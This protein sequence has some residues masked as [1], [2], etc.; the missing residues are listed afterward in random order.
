MWLLLSFV[1]CCAVLFCAAAA[2]LSCCDLEPA[3]P[4]NTNWTKS[5]AGKGKVCEKE[6]HGTAHTP[7]TA[8]AALTNGTKNATMDDD[9]AGH[10]HAGH[11]HSNG[12]KAAPARSGAGIASAGVVG[13]AAAALVM[14]LL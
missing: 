10:G 7:K 4:A 5:I 12:T 9:H 11:D 6:G 2:I 1:L 14:L 8:V 13:A 3:G